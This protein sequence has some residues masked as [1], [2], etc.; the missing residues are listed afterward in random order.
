MEDCGIKLGVIVILKVVR[1]EKTWD[2]STERE[3]WGKKFAEKNK[4]NRNVVFDVWFLL[5][6]YN[7]GGRL[8]F[9]FMSRQCRASFSTFLR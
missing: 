4:G 2:L 8:D 6:I 9:S 1:L 7:T 5:V 3:S